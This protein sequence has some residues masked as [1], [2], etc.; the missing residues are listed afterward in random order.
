MVMSHGVCQL[1][2]NKTFDQ[3]DVT[4]TLV[5]EKKRLKCPVPPVEIFLSVELLHFQLQMC[6]N[7]S[8]LLKI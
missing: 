5:F 4:Q 2:E 7:V 1:E 3:S 8:V 6:V